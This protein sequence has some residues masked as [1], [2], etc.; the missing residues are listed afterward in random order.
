[1]IIVKVETHRKSNKDK[2]FP[3]KCSYYIGNGESVIDDECA[4][5]FENKKQAKKFVKKNVDMT[6][7]N[8]EFKV[9]YIKG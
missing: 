1:M 9:K 6:D 5:R 2:T 8:F 7:G 4:R 3:N